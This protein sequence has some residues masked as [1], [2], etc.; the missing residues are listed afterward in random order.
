MLILTSQR[1]ASGAF[2][3]VL[4]SP[5]TN[6]GDLSDVGER[7]G[8]LFTV[9]AMAALAGP[10]ISG[11]INGATKDFRIVG[12]YAGESLETPRLPYLTVNS[13]GSM[14]ILCVVFMQL[15]RYVTTGRIWGGKC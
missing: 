5:V 4:P 3:S 13:I 10:P 9:A 11:A 7:V 8:L 14:I 6:L 15:S 12:A 1:A 2:V